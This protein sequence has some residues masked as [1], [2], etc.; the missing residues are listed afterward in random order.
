MEVESIKELKKA[1]KKGVSPIVIK[2][3][4]LKVAVIYTAKKKGLLYDSSGRDISD[5]PF[6]QSIS[7]VFIGS[8][9]NA[10]AAKTTV[11]LSIT[12]AVLILSLYAI[13]K[14]RNLKV[15]INPDGVVIVE[16]V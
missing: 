8:G 9:L 10:V 6:L 16:V 3:K 1:V 5:Q 11:I 15:S 7:P 2:D 12:A 13:Y 4:K 14:E